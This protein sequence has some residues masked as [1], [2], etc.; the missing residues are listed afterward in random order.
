MAEITAAQVK[1]LR[2]RTGLP[3]MDCKQAL[4]EAD[5]DEE[6]AIEIL[7]K[8]GAAA[9]EKKAG[10]ETAE[11]RIACF[12]SADGKVGAIV[13][14]R[15][16]TAPVASNEVFRQVAEAIAKQVATAEK[17]AGSADELLEQPFVDDPGRTVREVLNDA[18]NKIRENL[19]L[20]RF[21]RLTG[22]KVTQYVHFNG[23]VGVLVAAEPADADEQV[24]A[25]VCMQI[26]AMRPMAVRREDVPQEIVEK[27]REIARAQIQNKPE[28][29]IDRIVEG[30]LNKWFSERVLLEQ[31]FIK[32]EKGKMTVGD[33]LKKAGDIKVVKFVRMEVG[34]VE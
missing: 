14:M 24:L 20:S 28:H 21:T 12:V 34:E 31:P 7:R 30:K 29:I 11:G 10:R 26:A 17:L 19:T 15:C 33:V 32:D 4:I 25:D 27:E 1:A 16:E 5:G 13:E 22:E 2:D 8:R 18:I 3:M 9:A 6:K 23:Q